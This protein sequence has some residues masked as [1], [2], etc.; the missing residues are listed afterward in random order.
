[1][2]SSSRNISVVLSL[3]C[4]SFPRNYRINFPSFNLVWGWKLPYTFFVAGSLEADE[5]CQTSQTSVLVLGT[6]LIW[7]LKGPHSGSDFICKCC[8]PLPRDPSLGSTTESLSLYIQKPLCTLPGFAARGASF[9]VPPLLS[10]SG[11]DSAPECPQPLVTFL[12]AVNSG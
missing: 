2:C 4:S 12:A 6:Y 10:P 9:L 1:M 3:F 7:F 11:Q 8:G 5:T